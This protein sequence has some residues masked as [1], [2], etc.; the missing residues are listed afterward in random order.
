[1]EKPEQWAADA[2]S[3]FSSTNYLDMQKRW[4]R[5]YDLYN[6]VPYDAGKGFYSFTTN[7]PRLVVNKGVSMITDAKL[8]I[9][10]PDAGLLPLPEREIASNI[11][12]FCYGVINHVDEKFSRLPNTPSLREQ[13]AWFSVVRGFVTLCILI[14]KDE[15]TLK[16][17]INITPWDIYNV[18]YCRRYR[19]YQSNTSSVRK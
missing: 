14:Y 15:K 8:N 6:L 12:R 1:M 16:T 18:A 4:D 10:V 17:T 9:R 5:D 11:E 2:T 13:L 7:R 3:F 19:N